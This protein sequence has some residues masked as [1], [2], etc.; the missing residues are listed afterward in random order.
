[1][2]RPRLTRRE[3]MA[4]A[5]AVVGGAVSGAFRA[6]CTWLLDALTS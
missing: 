6:A 2:S 1:M 3:R 5:C 4:L